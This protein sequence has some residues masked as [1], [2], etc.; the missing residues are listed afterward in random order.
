LKAQKTTFSSRHGLGNKISYIEEV[1]NIEKK[2][3]STRE[4]AEIHI[5]RPFFE[6]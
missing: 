5:E 6:K 2:L 3:F 1:W 4:Y